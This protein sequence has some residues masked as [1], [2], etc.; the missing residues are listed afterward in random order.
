MDSELQIAYAQCESLARGRRENFPVL[1][2]Y[3]GREHAHHLA[4]VY[5]FCRIADDAAD[6]SNNPAEALQRLEELRREIE[7]IYS[8]SRP[9]RLEL[10]ALGNTAIERGLQK[11]EFTDLLDAFCQ[12]QT[13]TRYANWAELLEYSRRSANPVGRL[14]LATIGELGGGAAAE[15]LN[16]S[17]RVCTGLQLANFWQDVAADYKKGRIY[18]PADA[19]ARHAVDE[20]CIRDARCDERFRALMDELCETT[21]PMFV[22]G[23]ALAD[24]V[25]RR[26]RVPILAFAIAGADLL[27]RIRAAEYDIYNRRPEI[28]DL[29]LKRILAKAAAASFLPI[30]RP[31]LK[32]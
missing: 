28:G 21:R 26:M 17:D 5:A 7:L 23:A 4:A 11:S 12:D 22:E 2:Q 25:G 32:K 14:V 13:K 16:L 30:L 8:G 9:R 19:M 29:P 6:E 24:L 20:S 18:I 3:I 1:S 10:R 27:D 31:K 15:K